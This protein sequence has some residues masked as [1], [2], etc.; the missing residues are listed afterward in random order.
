MHALLEVEADEAELNPGRRWQLVA[1]P[2]E[3]ALV[4]PVEAVE[5]QHARRRALHGEDRVA[6][7]L[8]VVVASAH[9]AG[10]AELEYAR[11]RRGGPAEVTVAL[12]GIQEDVVGADESGGVGGGQLHTVVDELALIP[13]RVE[14]V[15]DRVA[16]Q[17]GALWV[18]VAVVVEVDLP[19]ELDRRVLE[20]AADS[21]E[22]QQG[23]PA[24]GRTR[25]RS[26]DRHDRCRVAHRD[27][28]RGRV[29][30]VRAVGHTV[31]G[32]NGILHLFAVILQ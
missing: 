17:V 29:G 11:Y 30:L 16:G 4:A 27:V 14:L 10:R 6:H 25:G 19:D 24:E 2:V 9:G 31:L 22:L 28:E 5:L 15:A 18:D 21:G 8:D 3:G 20:V 12:F 1:D 7:H 26:Q 32:W 23:R 13:V